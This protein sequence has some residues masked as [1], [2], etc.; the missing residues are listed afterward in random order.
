MDGAESKA[1]ANETVD[2][3]DAGHPSLLPTAPP[4]TNPPSPSP[5]HTH[6]H[7]PRL[8]RAQVYFD[9]AGAP[10]VPA[11]LARAVS[12]V[13]STLYGN[14]HSVGSPSAAVAADTVTRAREK[15]LAFLDTSP[16][17]YTCIFTAN[18]TAALKLVAESIRWATPDDIRR[19]QKSSSPNSTLTNESTHSALNNG[20]SRSTLTNGS[21][22]STKKRKSGPSLP[23]ASRA[24]PRGLSFFHLRESHTSALGMREFVYQAAGVSSDDEDSGT[25]DDDRGGSSNGR[26]NGHAA[27]AWGGMDENKCRTHSQP[28]TYPSGRGR[29]R[30]VSMDQ[31]AAWCIHADA[32]VE[33]QTEPDATTPPNTATDTN[34][35]LHPAPSLFNLLS[36]PLQCNFSGRRTPP[37]LIRSLLLNPTAIPTLPTLTASHRATTTSISASAS[38]SAPPI[39][40]LILL[41]A[42]AHLSTHP[43]SLR[44]IPA[45]FAVLSFYK[46][47]GCPDGLGALV[48][49]N[50]ALPVLWGKRYFGGGAV[51]G[52]GGGWEEHSWVRRR[53]D[54]EVG[55]GGVPPGWPA[56]ASLP[57]SPSVPSSPSS[58]TLPAPSQPLPPSS[59]PAR[60]E[61]GTLPF[62]SIAALSACF[63]HLRRL[64]SALPDVSPP[65][66]P[67]APAGA[68]TTTPR[69]PAAHRAMLLA[70]S[71]AIMLAGACFDA[72]KALR[73]HDGTPA[74]LLYSARPGYGRGTASSRNPSFHPNQGPLIAFNL[75]RPDGSLVGYTRVQTLANAWGVHVRSGCF[76]NTGACE[77]ALGMEA[78][79]MRRNLELYGHVCSDSKDLIAGR[80]TGALRISFGLCN[81]LSD[82]DTWIRLLRAYFTVAAPACTPVSQP[83]PRGSGPAVV[84]Q[85]AVFPIKSCG[86]YVVPSGTPWPIGD[87]GFVMDRRFAIVDASGSALSQKRVPLM[88]L[89]RSKRV[90]VGS[91]VDGSGGWVDVEIGKEVT[92]LE[93]GAATAVATVGARVCGDRVQAVPTWSPSISC[94]VS[95]FLDIANLRFIEF[96]S[97]TARK[98]RLMDRSDLARH[99]SNASST[100]SFANES[101]FL[102]INRASH[103]D[104]VEN[105]KANTRD[106]EMLS[107]DLAHVDVSCYRANII[108]DG[109]LPW[110]EETWV[111]RT[112][113]FQGPSGRQLFR[114]LARCGR[115][116]MVCVDQR[117]GAKGREPYGSMSRMERKE[118]GR[119]TFGV[120]LAHVKEGSTVPFVL[121]TGWTI[122]ELDTK[123][124]NEN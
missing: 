42:A 113:A 100:I 72:M 82:V 55:G 70:S 116:S 46:I 76:C 71:H 96:S 86:A 89:V 28:A 47:F 66:S 50:D 114:V 39:P 7:N 87:S 124:E 14:P 23:S 49:R 91:L 83:A 85:L 52:V 13:M 26:E 77:V 31:I 92:R 115:C 121:Q 106:A 54:S 22:H 38:T 123:N 98:S 12:E 88:C 64:S 36:V 99:H 29:V 59:A 56:W 101:Q 9:N 57:F 25:D 84:D 27:N 10:P 20:S 73:H 107:E 68:G 37:D 40:T 93:V 94:Q 32:V 24:R 104:M 41:D 16:D 45:H 78:G 19:A 65:S 51:D 95:S 53:G 17:E 105:L 15:V 35:P 18:A 43:L 120:H 67:Y 3:T 63:A 6:K 69:D 119:V 44:H 48:V 61:D 81:T 74:C 58:P 34:A 2:S 4:H 102:L 5:A 75:I 90:H 117:T 112:I 60:F 8:R 11:P 108:V 109:I 62:L 110:I 97:T 1:S 122:H 118:R 111:G 103:E 21:T 30:A 80:P 79:E 33:S